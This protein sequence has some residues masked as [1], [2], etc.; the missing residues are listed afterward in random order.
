VQLCGD[1]HLSNFGLYAS[2]E[3]ALL[4]GVN[5]FDETLPGPFDWDL[6]RLATSFVLAARNNGFDAEESRA[7]AI[8]AA[9]SY[10]EHM[11]AYAEMRELDVWY[12]NVVAEDLLDMVR[13]RSRS[14][15]KTTQKIAAKARSRDSLQAAGKL[16]QS[17]D[18]QTRFIEQ[19][20]LIMHLAELAEAEAT[21]ELLHQ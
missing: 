21:H 4:F 6:K 2:P 9:R 11:A 8:A 10:R 7:A 1:A 14:A 13:R 18:G 17:I 16:T 15:A 5:D 12:S 3:R 20:P 19:P